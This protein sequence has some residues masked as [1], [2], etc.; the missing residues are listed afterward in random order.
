MPQQ[1]RAPFKQPPNTLNFTRMNAPSKIFFWFKIILICALV[2][3]AA[4]FTGGYFA[5]HPEA[6]DRL[7]G[8]NQPPVVPGQPELPPL[9]GFANDDARRIAVVERVTPAVVSIIVSKDVPKY[10]QYSFN[11][12]GG[13][14]FFGGSQFQVPAY[15][16]NG[17]EHREIGAGSGFI[18][19]ADGYI[20][21]NKHVVADE[22][23]DY[24]VILQDDRKFPAKVLARDQSNDIAVLKVEATDLIFVPFADSDNTKVG[25]S[26]LAIGYA[27][28]RFGNSVSSGIVSGIGRSIEAG[29]SDGTSEQLFDVVQTDAAINPGNSGGPLL[30]LDGHVLG[31]NVARAGADSIGFALP[32]N[33][34]KSVYESVRVS[35][36]IIRPFLGVRYRPVTEELQKANQLPVNYGALVIRGA[37]P[38]DLA[39]MP[40]SPADVAGIV[41]NDVILEV[42]G[43]KVTLDLPLAVLLRKYKAGDTI[44][45]KILHRGSEKI[46]E[47]KLTEKI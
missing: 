38:N 45:L 32:I 31:M 8:R 39:V 46:V 6:L 20:L 36:R 13:D 42:E 34:I 40:S 2:S 11:P 43:K 19:S 17:T 10:E 4:G 15:R 47:V 28:G 14:P 1:I 22:S 16:Q 21:T 5:V 44:H 7:I 18:V 33:D 23:A 24:T 35:G 25:Q 37:Q 26:V 41:E 9:P 29:D 3:S 12:F 30:N 27:L